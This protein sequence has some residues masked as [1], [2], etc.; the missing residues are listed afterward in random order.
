MTSTARVRTSAV[1]LVRP[2]CASRTSPVRARWGSKQDE[3]MRPSR[4]GRQVALLPF[5][6]EDRGD[7]RRGPVGE[8]IRGKRIVL[9]D[10][11]V[12]LEVHQG[13]HVA[14]NVVVQELPARAGG[15]L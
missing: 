7:R 3:R 6:L 5:P 10:R 13:G 9:V 12:V 11:A 2:A 1:P 4:V 15:I 8:L 14:V